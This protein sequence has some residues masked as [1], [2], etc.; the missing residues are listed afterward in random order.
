MRWLHRCA[1]Y[2]M[3]AFYVVP[4]V[5][6]GTGTA[7][8]FAYRKW[9]GASVCAAAGIV[10]AVVGWKRLHGKLIYTKTTTHP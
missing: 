5:T 8:L 7:T 2:G 10:Y 9:L 3:R 4:V 1:L 6:F